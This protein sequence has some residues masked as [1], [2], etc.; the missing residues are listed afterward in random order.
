MADETAAIADKQFTTNTWIESTY[1]D[2]LD[3][4]A[5]IGN[6]AS[7]YRE[8]SFNENKSGSNMACKSY[9]RSFSNRGLL[10]G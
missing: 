2:W 4:G 3:A 7:C 9:R 1:P 8:N 6:M 10:L 5:S